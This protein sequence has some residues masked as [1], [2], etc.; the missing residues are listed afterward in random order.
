MASSCVVVEARTPKQIKPMNG[1][2]TGSKF[3]IYIEVVNIVVFRF[4]RLQFEC[5]QIVSGSNPTLRRICPSYWNMCW[6]NDDIKSDVLVGHFCFDTFGFLAIGAGH[7]LY[8]PAGIFFGVISFINSVL[9][10]SQPSMVMH[11]VI[12]VKTR[13]WTP[14][15]RGVAG[16]RQ[17]AKIRYF[18]GTGWASSPLVLLP[19]CL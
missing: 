10:E 7:H 15:I 2:R 13:T 17:A 3:H 11:K 4:F 5:N 9:G 16:D 12:C 14:H 6:T 18:R 19:V 1:P 8:F